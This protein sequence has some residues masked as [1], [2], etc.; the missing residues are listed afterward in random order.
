VNKKHLSEEWQTF[1]QIS[2]GVKTKDKIQKKCI[3]SGEN[4]VCKGLEEEVSFV[5]SEIAKLV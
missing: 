4:S 2:K 5:Y 3:P 1:S